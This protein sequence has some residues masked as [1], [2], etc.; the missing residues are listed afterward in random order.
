MLKIDNDF[1][2]RPSMRFAKF[3]KDAAFIEKE[4]KARKRFGFEVELWDGT[5]VK[6]YF[7]FDSAAALYTR[8]SA[9]IDPYRLTHGL[10]QEA[11]ADGARVYD[12]TIVD[13]IERLN[14]GVI[15]HTAHGVKVRA[16]KVVIACGY[17]SANYLP[18]KLVKLSSTYAFASE[19]LAR[20][21]IWFE[22]CTFWDTSDPYAYGRT[23]VDNRIIFGGEDEP[24]YDPKRRDNL[25]PR[26]TEKLSR[27]FRKMF[28]DLDF[29]PDYSWAGTFIE[30]DDGLPYIGTIDQLPHTYFALG[31]GGNGITFSQM[32]AD[33]L[34][35]LLLGK[36]NKDAA[37]FAFDRSTD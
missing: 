33:I 1:E 3:K 19:P 26:K 7:P 14:R 17:E 9:V 8:P 16:K 18:K 37:I 27:T 15:L 35:D 12:K 6:K 13:K 20:E 29:K 10:L 28:P 4:F 25:L 24:F 32:A 22:N 5:D 23:T 11:A 2:S 36:M 30:T 21:E 34:T 31:Y